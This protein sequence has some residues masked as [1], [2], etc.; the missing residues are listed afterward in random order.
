VREDIR[1]LDGE[2]GSSQCSVSAFVV[3]CEGEKIVGRLMQAV[4][5]IR[6]DGNVFLLQKKHS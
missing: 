4:L 2:N 1:E 5:I 6:P 3:I